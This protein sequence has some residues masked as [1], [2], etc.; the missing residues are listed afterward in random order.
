MQFL[1][2]KPNASMRFIRTG[3]SSRVYADM[4]PG[5]F[6][7]KRNILK[8][9][10]LSLILRHK[11]MYVK[12]FIRS[13]IWQ[14]FGTIA[15]EMPVKLQSLLF[16]QPVSWFRDFARLYVERSH[17]VLKKNI[18]MPRELEFCR[19]GYQVAQQTYH[20]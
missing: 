8:R 2:H 5:S 10:D 7:P 20:L 3:F 16:Y 9:A 14:V 19:N 18:S 6:F 15:T 11:E 1:K 13:Y 17:A 12:R 4:T